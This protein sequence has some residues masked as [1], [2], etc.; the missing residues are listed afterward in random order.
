MA[1]DKTLIR[2]RTCK[3]MIEVHIQLLTDA[4]RW[5]GGLKATRAQA[6]RRGALVGGRLQPV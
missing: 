5:A 2:A 1:L 6:S 3:V 4:K